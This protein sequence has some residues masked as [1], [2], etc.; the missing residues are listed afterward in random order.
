MTVTPARTTANLSRAAIL[1]LAVATAV[2]PVLAAAPDLTKTR[3]V[4]F[5]PLPPLPPDSDL[6][7]NDGAPDYHDLFQ[8]GAPWSDAA[9][10]IDV[11]S[12]P[13]TWVRHYST[14]GQLERLIEGLQARG[15]ALGME[16]GPLPDFEA[17][18][19]GEGFGGIYEVDLMRQI[20]D[21][22]G[23]VDVIIFDEP[24]GFG[25]V[26]DAPG[27]CQWSVDKVARKLADFVAMT[28]E[29]FPD[30]VVGGN[31]PLWSAPQVAPQD[32]AAWL[33]AY[34]RAAGEPLAFLHID[35]E[36]SWPGWLDQATAVRAALVGRGVRVGFIY[37]GGEIADQEGWIAAA[38]ER[39][40]LLESRSAVPPDDVVFQSWFDQPDR[41]LP[42][43]D[44]T[45]FTGLVNRYFRPHTRID[46]TDGTSGFVR[47][48]DGAP[49]A[50]VPVRAR[51]MADA[52]APRTERIT[53][54]V[55]VS[56]RQ[57]VAIFRVNG[58]GA[59]TTAD[60]DMPVESVGYMEG[61]GNLAPNPDF[62]QKGGW[63]GYGE[64]TA[65]VERQGSGTLRLVAR[66]DEALFV[67]SDPF[68]V[69]PGATF[70]YEVTATVPVEKAGAIYAGVVFLDEY[71]VERSG[72][73]PAPGPIEL[74]EVVTSADGSFELDLSGAIGPGELR[75]TVDA[76]GYWP[77]FAAADVGG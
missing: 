22:G 38:I 74:P 60:V 24:F 64:G 19:K 51:F 71:E 8:P 16:V 15:I 44:P 65:R 47:T 7:F 27:A 57:A 76:P 11:F 31:E 54:T 10:Q 61:G 20:R 4:F 35:S 1:I 41:T 28:R 25:H 56:A 32:V 62:R 17:C 13:S 6:P 69:T 3:L 2:G 53:G 9:R 73:N 52:G 49:V 23:T 33:D 67:D 77:S 55:P 40:Y 63:G 75:L 58:E 50:G 26:L 21:L 45:S 12:I 14:R 68:A 18:A 30:A 29:V 59:R 42:D 36:W 34:A 46:L 39:A 43:G 66:K 70:T 72:L 37:N 5:A 48:A